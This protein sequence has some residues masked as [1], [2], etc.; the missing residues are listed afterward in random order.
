MEGQTIKQ[1]GFLV[2][3]TDA[4]LCPEV[5]EEVEEAGTDEEVGEE[6]IEEPVEPVDDQTEEEA[7]GNDEE[8][9]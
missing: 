4:S 5:E 6:A 9:N 3:T 2:Y 8:A 1:L 7:G